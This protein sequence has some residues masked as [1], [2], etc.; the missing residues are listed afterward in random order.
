MRSFYRP[1]AWAICIIGLSMLAI[2]TATAQTTT[3]IDS[4]VALVD[5]DIIL[6]SELDIAIRGII[7]RIRQQGGDLPPQSLIE[8][9]QD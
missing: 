6:R 3:K 7:D 4:V 1:A 9:H 5:D 2:N 8:K